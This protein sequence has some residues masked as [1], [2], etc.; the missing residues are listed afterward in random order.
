[1]TPSDPSDGARLFAQIARDL[2]AL[3]SLTQVRN[4][5]VRLAV[6]LLGADVATVWMPAH[7]GGVASIRA[8]A[9]TDPPR[10]SQFA[11]VMSRLHEGL[12]W[13][14][15][16]LRVTMSVVD[17]R[18]DSR[19][20]NLSAYLEHQPA[21]ALLSVAGFSLD[22]GERNLGALTLASSTADFFTDHG[23]LVA[24]VLA[25]H[26]AISLDAI[27]R[28]EKITNLQRAMESNKR[29]GIALGVLMHSL[30]VD[31]LHAFSLLRSA[32]QASHRKLF[33]VAEEVILTG[34]PPQLPSRRP[35]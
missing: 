22:V 33:E 19:W 18:T 30:G 9:S 6:E 3:A 4:R 5:I 21:P 10:A 32:S 15:L 31:E 20:P 35:R 12:A 29:I 1:M 14:C 17:T 27:G 8:V 2:F 13:D 23:M 11:E 7:S 34:A 26:A 25:E 24:S 16:Q 28:A